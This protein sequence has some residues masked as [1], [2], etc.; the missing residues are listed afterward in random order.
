MSRQ[1]RLEFYGESFYAIFLAAIQGR[2]ILKFS[3]EK[4]AKNFRRSLYNFRYAL[5][6]AGYKGNTNATQKFK[7]CMKVQINL[8]QNCLILVNKTL[9]YSNE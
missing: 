6:D 3:D 4:L 5:R 1:R 7:Q 8:D 9:E 2:Y